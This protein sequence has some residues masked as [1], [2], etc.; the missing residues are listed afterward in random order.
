MKPTNLKTKGCTPISSDC[1]VWQGPDIA[2]I[3]L[4]KGDSVSQV[5]YKLA[6]ELCNILEQLDIDNYDLSCFN[7]SDC[8]PT[9]FQQ[10]IEFLIARICELEGGVDQAPSSSPNG[11]PD[12]VVNMAPCF[13]YVDPSTGDT[14]T[15]NQLTNYVN[16]IGLRVCTLVSQITTIQNTLINHENRII[17]LE[18]TPPPSF[19]LPSFTPACVLS[20]SN[21]ILQILQALEL[22][23]CNLRSA[24]GTHIQLL[25]SI[26][27][28]CTNLATSPKLCGNGTMNTIP[29]WVNN[30]TTLADSIVNMW[31]TICDL[32]CSVQS[33]LDNCCNSPCSQVEIDMALSIISSSGNDTLQISVLG[34]IP[35]GFV[36]CSTGGSTVIISDGSSF[37]TQLIDFIPIIG[38]S[39]ISIDLT[40]LGLT[41]PTVTVTA[42][43]CFTDGQGNTCQSQTISSTGRTPQCPPLT[44]TPT[45]NSIG[46]AFTYTGGA[47]NITVQLF[48]SLGTVLLQSNSIGVV[49]P[50]ILSGSFTGLLPSTQY[51][52]RI[53]ITIGET[54][55]SCPLVITN[56][57]PSLCPD[58]ENVDAQITIP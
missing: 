2:C 39:P 27:N 30:P 35:S 22:Q 54:T 56:T 31:L 1:V 53:Q 16:L 57:L 25:Q 9:T 51:R 24:T 6:E 49:G 32:R 12:C 41:G 50:Y 37:I 26:Q 13:H 29:G 3:N 40:A 10:L 19:I 18:N 20:G 14:V 55:T 46:Y 33:I 34:N 5:V 48:N 15:T 43:N 52:V 8:G 23:F 21:N 17:I 44:L 38:G 36:N 58:P 28:Q 42:T 47:A 45:S 7:L 11:C 4:C